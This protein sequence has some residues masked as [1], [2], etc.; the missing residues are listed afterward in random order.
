MNKAKKEYYGNL[1][2]HNVTDTKMVWKTVKPVFG[3]K[4]KICNTISLIKK[5]TVISSQKALA[6]TFYEFYV[7]IVSNLGIDIYKV[8]EVTTSNQIL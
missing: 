7:N 4:V 1:D 2:L 8:S 3:N 6:K 5:T